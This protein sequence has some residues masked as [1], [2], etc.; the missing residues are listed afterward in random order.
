[1]QV[2]NEADEVEAE[3]LEVR[4]EPGLLEVL[5]DHLG[6]RRQ[7]G[8]HP[9]LHRQAALDGLLGEEARADHDRGV[10]GVGAAG[11]GGDD[12]RAV[13]EVVA[14]SVVVD[15][16]LLH[17][18]AELGVVGGDHLHRREVG[19]AALVEPAG[20]LVLI[21]VAEILLEHAVEGAA[22]DALHVL[23]RNAVLRASRAGQGGLDGGE[24]ELEGVAELRL[25]GLG[26]DEDALLLAIG[27]DE[28][29]DL[30]GAAG[31]GQV[32]ERL[33]VDR[34]EAD[35]GAVL[36]R[37]VGDGGAVGQRERRDARAVE[38]HE[39]PDNVLLAEH[40]GDGEHGVGGRGAL[41]SSPVAKAAD[42]RPQLSGGLASPPR[43]RSAHCPTDNTQAVT[44]G[45]R[46]VAD[47]VSGR[48]AVLVAH[49][50]AVH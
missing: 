20:G 31:E 43:P 1:M 26:T 29:D 8:L 34:E 32:R 23:E 9:G 45:V 37:H 41:R 33:L 10:G 12:H 11:D 47:E 13:V 15:G 22:I 35:G 17:E 42:L 50:A 38:L 27:L 6:A 4:D 18:L 5:H 21:E 39:L 14:D 30:L 19:A 3:G 16:D 25:G 2:C 24:V 36:G 40:L 49:H 46:V 28:R 44:M 7:R 48:G